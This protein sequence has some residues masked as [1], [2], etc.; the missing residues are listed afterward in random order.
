M[1]NSVKFTIVI[2][3]LL[4]PTVAVLVGAKETF[5]GNLLDGLLADAVGIAFFGSIYF[6]SKLWK[7]R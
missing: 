5:W 1:K 7:S 6:L 3:L 4:A 2:M